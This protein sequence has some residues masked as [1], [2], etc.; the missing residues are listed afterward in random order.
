[1]AK[2]KLY[3]TIGGRNNWRLR[4]DREAAQFLR[5]F[6]CERVKV[7]IPGYDAFYLDNQMA[8]YR[9]CT[10]THPNL[11]RWIINNHLNRDKN[12]PAEVLPF[13]FSV[14][15]DIHTYRYIGRI[16]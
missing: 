14:E 9:Y 10:L 3:V 11:N 16:R 2:V 6:P 1:M 8:V 5:E 4:T 13:L 12:C 7:I 15:G